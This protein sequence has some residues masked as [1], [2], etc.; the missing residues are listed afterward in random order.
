MEQGIGLDEIALQ[1]I[2]QNGSISEEDFSKEIHK[3]IEEDPLILIRSLWLTEKYL[4][5]EILHML[6]P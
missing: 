4:P 3:V 1:I 6:E 2:S 5:P